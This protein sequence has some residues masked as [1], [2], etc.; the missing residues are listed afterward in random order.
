MNWR[1][2]GF[3]LAVAVLAAVVFLR[4]GD[5]AGDPVGQPLLPDLW[6]SAPFEL[7]ISE[8]EGSPVLRFTSEM[9][10][11]GDGDLLLRGD[12]N[13]NVDQ[14]I[15]HLESGHS[16]ARLEAEVVWGGDGH[17]HWHIKDV[18][19][20]WIAWPDGTPVGDEFD[21]KVGFCIFDSVDFQSGLPGAPTEVRHRIAGCGTRLAP[22]I[23][24]GLS[25]GWGDQYR[26]DLPGQFIDISGLA[27]GDYRLVA[28]VDPDGLLQEIDTTNN[29][30]YTE[31]SLEAD[32]GG[33]L[34]VITGERVG[35]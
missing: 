13:G 33:G 19:R 7:A 15:A 6:T 4:T 9:N 32:A 22:A 8:V 34:R 26:S 17:D 21:N 24:M 11:R 30:S 10:N 5:D 29:V 14:W 3:A 31:F 18:A 28:A 27:P 35:P 23:S 25:V 2:A 16:T 1:L 12:P 20:Y